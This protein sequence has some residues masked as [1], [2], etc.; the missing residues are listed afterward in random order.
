MSG[1]IPKQV[2]TQAE[3]P[4]ATAREL[5][6]GM[7]TEW[8][9]NSRFCLAIGPLPS[10][11]IV[12]R[13]RVD[14]A[15]VAETVEEVRQLLRERSRAQAAWFVSESSRPLDL[16]QRLR[17]LGL[18]PYEE[19]P[20]EPEYAA[21]AIVQPPLGTTIDGVVAR[22][23]ES[24]EELLTTI[25]IIAEAARMSEGDRTAMEARLDELFQLHESGHA[26][27]YV[28]FV[29]REPAGAARGV[30]QDAGIN[31]SGGGVLPSARGRGAY[32]A[33]VEARWRE[34]VE[35]GT[36]A[37]TVQAGRMSRPILERLGF[38]TVASMRV[39]CDRFE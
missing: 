27:T 9:R 39:F 24:H 38:T 33:L 4:L 8:I 36:P 35:R 6:P 12:Q 32:R 16:E 17:G 31:L 37:L 28:A 14:G 13:V 11:N 18:V 1:S 20:L 19:P 3:E 15:D 34:A 10:T 2:R 30:L 25:K 5:P 22:A 23:I 26:R 21:M 7:Q 29:D